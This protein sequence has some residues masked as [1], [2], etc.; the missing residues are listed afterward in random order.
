MATG[1]DQ[2]LATHLPAPKTFAPSREDVLSTLS[3]FFG[4]PY[5][6]ARFDCTR[7]PALPC[8]L[9]CHVLV[10]AG[11]FPRSCAT[12]PS[13][14]RCAQPFLCVPSIAVC[15]LTLHVCAHRTYHF[16]DAFYGQNTKLRETLNNLI[17]KS[18]QDWPTGVGLPFVRIQGTNVEWDELKFDV[19]LLQRVPYEG[20]SRMRA[21][22]LLDLRRCHVGRRFF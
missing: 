8:V 19:R 7:A 18:P 15:S 9:S 2:Q 21:F 22:A 14:T 6:K 16:P 1:A 10:S 17:L 20:V 4:D 3:F 13:I 12:T 11:P 5:A